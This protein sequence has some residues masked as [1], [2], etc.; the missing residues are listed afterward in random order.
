M[1]M[2]LILIF[3][4][5]IFHCVC[6]PQLIYHLSIQGYLSCL[7]G[8][9]IVNDAAI[10]IV[11]NIF[12]LT[13]FYP[14]W[15]YSQNWN[16]WILYCM[17]SQLCLILCNPMDSSWSPWG[18]SVHGLSYVRI[19]EW[20]AISFSRGSSWPRDRIHAS[21]I[22]H[23]AGRFFNHWVIGIESSIFNLLRISIMFSI[24][25][26]PIYY[27][28]NNVQWFFSLQLHQYLLSLIYLMIVILTGM[29]WNLTV[30]LIYLCFPDN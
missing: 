9:T 30:I 3:Y 22:S 5:C 16:W 28:T 19:L 2:V 18:S 4:G 23:I 15:M 21:C 6:I 24:G 10:D 12:R 13:G 17:H 25:I 26:V 27:C 29:R 1:K 20:I 14:P 7:H 11:K 8:M